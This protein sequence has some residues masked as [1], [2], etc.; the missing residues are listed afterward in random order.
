MNEKVRSHRTGVPLWLWLP[1]ALA[2]LA[3]GGYYGVWQPLAHHYLPRNWGV[4][5]EGWI[6]RSG[7]LPSGLVRDMLAEHKIKVVIA[8]Y[9]QDARDDEQQA[10]KQAVDELGIELKR[11]PLRGDG[12][13]GDADPVQGIAKYADAVAA[14][15]QARREGKPALVQCSAGTHRT[16]GVIATYRVLVER[17]PISKAYEELCDYGW[18]PAKHQH[19]LKFLNPAMD[20]VAARLVL[21]GAIAKI[22][23]PVPVLGP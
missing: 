22:P 4:V 10:M 7:E 8:L 6:Y 12:T 9:S 15:A 20:D 19:L 3:A 18:D 23:D 5:E 2:A 11:F 21:R 14:L 1:C 13:P 16:G 17:K